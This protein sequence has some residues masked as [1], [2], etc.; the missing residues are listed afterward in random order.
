MKTNDETDFGR[1]IKASN[2]D[3][4]FVRSML[5]LFVVRTPGMIDE[6]RSA[7]KNKDFEKTVRLAHKL[8]PSVDMIGSNKMRHLLL[9]I[10]AITKDNLSCKNS[11]ELINKFN[12]QSEIIFDL[13]N[14]KLK[15]KNRI[16]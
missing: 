2:G 5:Q 4:D 12:T 16:S 8:K 9:E 6:M 7:C 1:L 15:S 13:I 3:D 11:P 10:H 14:Q